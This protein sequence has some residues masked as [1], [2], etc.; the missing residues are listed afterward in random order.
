MHSPCCLQQCLVTASVSCGVIPDQ[1]VHGSSAHCSTAIDRYSYRIAGCQPG[2]VL[3]CQVSA[4]EALLSAWLQEDAWEEEDS[5][6]DAEA[7]E[8]SDGQVISART[9]GKKTA[10][11]RN[12]AARAK[13]QDVA[14]EAKQRLKQQRRDLQ[15]V[16][17]LEQELAGAG[18]P[19]AFSFIL[20]CT[21]THH[22]R[23]VVYQRGY[24]EWE[25]Q[26]Q[27][28][29]CNMAQICGNACILGTR[30]CALAMLVIRSTETR[31][32]T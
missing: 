7:D 18:S 19:H 2:E 11:D 13:D 4:A 10:A 32:D 30:V 6:D 27:L 9:K 17:Q 8:A 15:N 29:P 31:L 28:T 26:A 1:V 23:A 21:W 5:G 12:R 14:V 25:L 20:S 16:K 24:A 3:S 22:V